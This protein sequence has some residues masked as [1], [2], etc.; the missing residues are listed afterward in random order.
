MVD[1]NS[2]D[3]RARRSEFLGE[4]WRLAERLDLSVEEVLA[5]LSTESDR[6]VQRLLRNAIDELACVAACRPAHG[7]MDASLQDKIGSDTQLGGRDAV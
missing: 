1:L 3:S 4:V 6:L 7:G 5:A 2:M